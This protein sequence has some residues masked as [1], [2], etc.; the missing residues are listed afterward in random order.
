MA[1]TIND[2]QI[3][4]D[5]KGT[6]WKLKENI[7]DY[8]IKNQVLLRLGSTSSSAEDTIEY[9][10]GNNTLTKKSILI[11]NYNGE[12]III[13]LADGNITADSR[14]YIYKND[15]YISPYGEE[16]RYLTFGDWNAKAFS[17]KISDGDITEEEVIALIK[18]IADLVPEE[19]IKTIDDLKGTI[20][21]LKED[22]TTWNNEEDIVLAFTKKNYLS[23]FTYRTENSLITN[24]LQFAFETSYAGLADNTIA[25]TDKLLGGTTKRI[26]KNGVYQG[27]YGTLPR[28]LTFNDWENYT[29]I[30][31]N[32]EKF[33][34][35][36]RE[37]ADLVVEEPEKPTGTIV[38]VN[39]KILNKVNGKKV[40]AIHYGDK[41]WEL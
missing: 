16:P 24:Q 25:F 14:V 35:E 38:R 11:G 13:S 31:G 19:S 18:H 9:K 2:I 4:N 39:G 33:L 5:L 1:K 26:V 22:L 21:I 7:S 6:V 34:N 40:R 10:Y 12:K 3:I 8:A 30:L 20:W 32:E 17:G 37:I 23:P 36:L 27:T 41:T 28:K 29:L 15:E